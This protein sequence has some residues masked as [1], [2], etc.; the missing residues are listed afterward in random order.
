MNCPNCNSQLSCGCQKRKASDGKD[1]C[2]NCM[3]EY[4]NIVAGITNRENK[5]QTDQA[6][7]NIKVTVS[8][9]TVHGT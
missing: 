1:V 7:T 2:T 8:G 6:P 4:E 3:M 9:Q 5:I